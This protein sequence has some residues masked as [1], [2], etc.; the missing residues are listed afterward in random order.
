[1]D[2]SDDESDGDLD[3][4]LDGS[5]GDGTSVLTTTPITSGRKKKISISPLS[6]ASSTLYDNGVISPLDMNKSSNFNDDEKSHESDEDADADEE[7]EIPHKRPN[8]P[9]ESH[10]EGCKC[11]HCAAR[12]ERCQCRQ[13]SIERNFRKYGFT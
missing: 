5:L 1:M 3:G 6:Q 13:C 11:R 4:D 8:E 9:Y 7:E 10:W 12:N 2:E